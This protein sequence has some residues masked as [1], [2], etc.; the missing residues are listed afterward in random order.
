MEKNLF[1]VF[2]LVQK[3]NS[4]R[5]RASVR[6]VQMAGAAQTPKEQMA[7]A[8]TEQIEFLR[9]SITGTRKYIPRHTRDLIAHLLQES[10]NRLTDAEVDAEFARD[11]QGRL[12]D[13][14]EQEERYEAQIADQLK[15]I[16]LLFRFVREGDRGIRGQFFLYCHEND[17]AVD[18]AKFNTLLTQDID[19]SI[20]EISVMFSALGVED[21]Q[22]NG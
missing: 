17:L 2:G 7:A 5:N 4:K 10:M 12:D 11:L 6:T 1:L 15:L 21:E 3:P 20:H 13:F 9:A 14:H 19:Q 18:P 16:E 8:V 22:N